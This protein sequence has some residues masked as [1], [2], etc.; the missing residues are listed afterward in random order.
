VLS[1]SCLGSV[2]H[3]SPYF[4]ELVSGFATYVDGEEG[5]DISFSFSF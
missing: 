3:W 1:M 5:K 4:I 2:G